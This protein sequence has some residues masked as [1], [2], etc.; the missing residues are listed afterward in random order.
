MDVES[1]SEDC[2]Y[3]LKIQSGYF[4][5]KNI[6]LYSLN[7]AYVMY[8][9]CLLHV[10]NVVESSESMDKLIKVVSSFLSYHVD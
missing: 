7:M 10:F 5:G 8:G 4:V 2:P 3:L 1:L 9:T 6:P